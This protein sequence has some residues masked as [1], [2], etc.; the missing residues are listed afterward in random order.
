M[1]EE[2]EGDGVSGDSAL[3]PGVGPT[4]ERNSRGKGKQIIQCYV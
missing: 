1:M 2:S 4:Y 3:C